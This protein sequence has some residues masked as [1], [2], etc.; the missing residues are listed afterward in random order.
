[1]RFSFDFKKDKT[2]LV[3]IGITLILVLIVFG[4]ALYAKLQSDQQELSPDSTNTSTIQS[5]SSI[6]PV[7]QISISRIIPSAPLPLT[8]G[9]PYSFTVYFSSPVQPSVVSFVLTGNSLYGDD[10]QKTVKISVTSENDNKRYIVKTLE[11]IEAY[12][13]YILRVYNTR[14]NI[15]V[16]KKAFLTKDI[17]STPVPVNNLSLKTYLPYKTDSYSLEYFANRNIYIFH[18]IYNSDLPTGAEAQFN[19]AKADAIQ[20]IQSKGIDI[21]SIVIEWRNS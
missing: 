9:L 8:P 18:F 20:F 16:Y 10:P 7:E 4:I 21:N 3:Q 11:P 12:G 15:E 6:A 14:T 2:L 19:A 1:M 13:E 17:L 5:E